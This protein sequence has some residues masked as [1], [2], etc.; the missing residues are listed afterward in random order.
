M[1]SEELYIAVSLILQNLCHKKP[2]VSDDGS[3][4]LKDTFLSTFKATL[5]LQ[6]GSV[7]KGDLI[8]ALLYLDYFVSNKLYEPKLESIQEF[9][10]TLVSFSGKRRL[11]GAGSN[12]VGDL[13]GLVKLDPKSYLDYSEMLDLFV[14]DMSRNPDLLNMS[15]PPAKE[16]TAEDQLLEVEANLLRSVGAVA[17]L[18]MR[19]FR[20]QST[21]TNNTSFR[22]STLHTADTH[23]SDRSE[24]KKST[25]VQGISSGGVRKRQYQKKTGIRWRPTCNPSQ[26]ETLIKTKQSQAEE[27]KS[28]SQGVAPQALV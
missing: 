2:Q 26:Y 14:E 6:Y 3:L 25:K 1:K 21:E 5:I 22:T 8:A 7:Q 10:L 19:N 18:S 4:Y 23:A 17:P 20:Q 16:L 24:N 9:F 12:G 27:A 28:S 13:I 11:G 15:R